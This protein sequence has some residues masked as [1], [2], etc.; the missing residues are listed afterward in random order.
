MNPPLRILHLE[1]DPGDARLVQDT[2]KAEGFECETTTV[3]RGADFQAALEAGAFDLILADQR[4]PGF[5]GMEALQMARARCPEIPFVFVTGAIGE[6]SVVDLLKSGAS[7]LVM[8]ERL[9]RLGLAVRHAL[10]ES[11]RRQ[12]GA[13]N[14]LCRTVGCEGANAFP[15]GSEGQGGAPPI[16]EAAPVETLKKPTASAKQGGGPSEKAVDAGGQADAKE[17]DETALDEGALRRSGRRSLWILAVTLFVAEFLVMYGLA[18]MPDAPSWVH[19]SVDAFCMLVLSSP[20]LYVFALRPLHQQIRERHRAENELRHNRQHLQEVIAERTAELVASNAQLR[21][22]VAGQRQ[23][24]E[25]LRESEERVCQALQVGCMFAFQWNTKTDR[26]VRSSDGG[27]ILGIAGV[28]TLDTGAE[29]FERIHPEDREQFLA[30]V[31]QL[32]PAADRYR[33]HYRLNRGDG[34]LVILEET[35]RGFFDAH[36]QLAGIIGIAADVTGREQTQQAL[37][38]ELAVNEA[39]S[40]LFVP[41]IAPDITIEVVANAV[42]T[43]ALSLT[44]SQDGLVT[45]LDPAT[46]R[47]VCHALTVG[48]RDLCELEDTGQG[49][50]LPVGS[51]E[52]CKAIGCQA[53]NT[54]KAFFKNDVAGAPKA[55]NGIEAPGAAGHN[56]LG[57]PVFLGDELV[58]QILI[59]DPG[60]NY[61]DADVAAVARLA[62]RYALGIQRLRSEHELQAERDFVRAI[63][64][65]APALVVVLDAEGHIIRFNQACE[66][67][68][69]YRFEEVKGKAAWELLSVPEE[70]EQAKELLTRLS[71]GEAP[72]VGE[73]FWLG[74]NGKRPRIMWSHTVLKDENQ[75]VQY[76]I[77]TGVDVTEARAAEGKLRVLTR[78]MEAGPASVVITDGSGTITHINPA[79][80]QLTGY[81]LAEVVGKNP[82]V[83]KSGQ[84]PAEFYLALWGALSTGLEWRGEFCNRKKNGELFWAY[85]TIS[86]I[87]D[88]TGSVEH[89]VAVIVDVTERKCYEQALERSRLELEHKVAERTIDLERTVQ[90]LRQEIEAR[91]RAEGEIQHL[92]QFER[93]VAEISTEFGKLPSRRFED[94]MQECGRRLMEFLHAER[95]SLLE[96]VG[97]EISV[98]VSLTADGTPPVSRRR[99]LA[100]ELPWSCALVRAG[101][102]IYFSELEDLPAEAAVDKETYRRLGSKSVIV[103]PLVATADTVGALVFATVTR[104]ATWPAQTVHRLRLVEDLFAGLLVRWRSQVALSEAE[105]RYHAVADSIQGWEYWESPEG[106]LLFCSPACARITGF[107]PQEFLVKP[108]LLHDIV[109]PEDAS[110]W[111]NFHEQ[112]FAEPKQRSCQFRI[113]R[114]DGEIRWIEHH[115]QPVTDETG[116]FLGLRASH[117]DHTTEKQAELESQ[118]LREEFA[119]VSRITTADHLAASLAHELRQPLSAILSNTEAAQ[120]FLSQNPPDLAEVREALDDIIQNDERAGHV[121]QRLRA[122]YRRTD[123]ERTA[124]DLNQLVEETLALL[125]S[126]LIL[127]QVS[128]RQNLAPGLPDVAVNRVEI[129]QVLVNLAINAREAMSD[130]PPGSR[131]LTIS[132]SLDAPD[133]IRVSVS[134]AGAGLDPVAMVHLF[135]PFFTTKPSGMGMGLAISRSIIEAHGGRFWAGNNP[136]RGATFHFTIPIWQDQAR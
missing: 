31:W 116:K 6:E 128:W 30:T 105:A 97:D 69:G 63:L 13:T 127:R 53:L 57:M 88:E 20:L 33:S 1:D 42:L 43:Q 67:A 23:V 89:F 108:K 21:Q 19:N 2:L 48:C 74:R 68:G 78:A 27:G 132:S 75:V 50:L 35:G 64:A 32:Q 25:A 84:H 73:S 45:T 117:R 119:R 10:A 91:R 115:S 26:I 111:R 51:E 12:S 124:V 83:W 16:P 122:L 22:T 81:S 114:I 8:K 103:L 120:R 37:R 11:K 129:Q 79:F 58:G 135:E 93:L 131:Q 36:G 17:A 113:R 94:I 86:P 40:R 41:L 133:C 14:P 92:L 95:V 118:R 34:S 49:A 72:L 60:R 87:K 82:R 4:L 110:L 96:F 56:I 107:E 100:S 76:V 112:A 47:H 134:D 52:Q 123:R 70:V 66:V 65:A 24:E 104:T 106:A 44:G 77:S 130:N 85:T 125:R 5:G 15:S 90:S 99:L 28:A 80:A 62:E 38:W 102:S 55:E 126:D 3:A 59:A 39:V 61:T 136:D 121:I 109:L 46:K 101:S 7:D 29:F 54:G 18:W 9:S 98:T 71:R